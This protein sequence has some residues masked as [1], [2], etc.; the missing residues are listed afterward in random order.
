MHRLHWG[1][2]VSSSQPCPQ[3]YR[4]HLEKNATQMADI[5][6]QLTEKSP[7]G[8]FAANCGA[9]ASEKKVASIPCGAIC[10]A[11]V[12]VLGDHNTSPSVYNTFQSAAA[13][14]ESE[15]TMTKGATPMMSAQQ[16]ASQLLEATKKRKGK[17]RKGKGRKGSGWTYSSRR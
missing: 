11:S 3:D 5:S 9:A 1:T 17:G 13:P 2:K 4:C 12:A 8:H 7:V 10:A 14:T 16:A 15:S 6:W